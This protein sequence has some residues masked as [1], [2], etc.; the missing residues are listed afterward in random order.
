MRLAEVL[1][2]GEMGVVGEGK[3]CMGEGKEC[4]GEGKECLGEGKEC[5]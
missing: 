4:V 5:G 2:L 3:E 1:G